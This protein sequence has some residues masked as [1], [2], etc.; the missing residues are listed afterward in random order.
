MRRGR[1]G[2]SRTRGDK[3]RKQLERRVDRMGMSA[4]IRGS[5]M[6]AKEVTTPT[7]VLGLLD[8]HRYL[9][10]IPVKDHLVIFSVSGKHRSHMDGMVS[11]YPHASE[12][13]CT[14]ICTQALT[15]GSALGTDTSFA[16]LQEKC[17]KKGFLLSSIEG[18]HAHHARNRHLFI[19]RLSPS[20]ILLIPLFV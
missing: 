5:V 9:R 12:G 10:W 20:L 4:V 7:L 18:D 6:N 11:R 15:Q 14:R 16:C 3:V 8:M 19:S 2:R 13:P 17:I 1:E